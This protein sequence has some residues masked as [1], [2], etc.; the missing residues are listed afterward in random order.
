MDYLIIFFVN[1]EVFNICFNF[2]IFLWML[3]VLNNAF[4]PDKISSIAYHI[5]LAYFQ[6]FQGQFFFLERLSASLNFISFISRFV[7]FFLAVEFGAKFVSLFKLF[8]SCFTNLP[9]ESFCFT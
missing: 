9:S 8:S 6:Y 1:F 4:T 3:L 7:S 2:F 5:K